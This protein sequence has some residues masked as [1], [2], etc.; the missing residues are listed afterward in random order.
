MFV[1]ARE[2]GTFVDPESEKKMGQDR[3]SGSL[4]A[5]FPGHDH[6]NFTIPGGTIRVPVVLPY[7]V[8]GE[9]GRDRACAVVRDTGQ[10]VG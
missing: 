10:E 4:T 1:R 3:R 2:I 5:V 9:P 7:P 8:T 6:G